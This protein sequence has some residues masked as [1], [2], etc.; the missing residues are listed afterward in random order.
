[1]AQTLK[2]TDDFLINDQITPA[3]CLITSNDLIE[4]PNFAL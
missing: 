4:D 1:M 3:K 2:Q